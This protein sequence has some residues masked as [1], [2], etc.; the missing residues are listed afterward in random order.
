[1]LRRGKVRHRHKGNPA[2]WGDMAATSHWGRRRHKLFLAY[3]VRVI[4]QHKNANIFKHK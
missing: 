2:T 3:E 4:F 1:M